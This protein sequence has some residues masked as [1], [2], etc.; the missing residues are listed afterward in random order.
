MTIEVL[1][2][3]RNKLNTSEVMR[4]E[5]EVL[6]DDVQTRLYIG[7]KALELTK[8]A[9]IPTTTLEFNQS[10]EAVTSNPEGERN[11][12]IYRQAYESV[13]ALLDATVGGDGAELSEKL[14]AL[15]NGLDTLSGAEYISSAPEFAGSI[16]AARENIG[17]LHAYVSAGGA[18]RPDTVANTL[19]EVK[20]LVA[21]TTV[22]YRPRA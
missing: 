20:R 12:D 2:P 1:A 9:D 16:K 21:S 13:V 19:A 3:D 6:H 7:I 4:T 11:A 18:V 15:A 22:A 10:E 17:Q 5:S 14:T 8:L